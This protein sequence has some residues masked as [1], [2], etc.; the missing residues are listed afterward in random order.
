MDGQLLGY[1]TATLD[2][3]RRIA[4][5]EADSFCLVA[6]AVASS[7]SGSLTIPSLGVLI[8]LSVK[9]S[10]L[11]FSAA[12]CAGGS[13]SETLGRVEAD[14]GSAHAAAHSYHL[15]GWCWYG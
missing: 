10:S 13:S 12:I 6:S 4:V 5:A 2:Q 14:L 15:P 3:L 8:W 9:V 1:A 11:H 7:P